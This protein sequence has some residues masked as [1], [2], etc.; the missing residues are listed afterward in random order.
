MKCPHCNEI[1][2]H[3]HSRPGSPASFTG[4]VTC[5]HEYCL[6]TIIGKEGDLCE[7]CALEDI[8]NEDASCEGCDHD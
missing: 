5:A 4:Y 7:D 1:R 2:D 3:F 6:A 8:G